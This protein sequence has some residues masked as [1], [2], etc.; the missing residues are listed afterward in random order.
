VVKVE[1]VHGDITVQQVESARLVLY[2]V[3]TFALADRLLR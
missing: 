1:V 3:R 2:D